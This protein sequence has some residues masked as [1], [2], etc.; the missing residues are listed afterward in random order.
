M[1]FHFPQVFEAIA[2]AIPDREAVVFGDRRLSY[3]QLRDRSRQLAQL[4]LRHG[5]G[6][7]RDPKRQAG[8]FLELGPGVNFA[9]PLLGDPRFGVEMSW[10]FYQDLQGPQV[11][12]DWRVTTGL[13]WAF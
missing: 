12:R 10:P 3:S 1:E 7:E 11:E 5:L 6:V 4:L 2:A 8:D 13:E 9:V